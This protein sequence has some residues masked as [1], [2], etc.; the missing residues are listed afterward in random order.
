[1]VLFKTLDVAIGVT[2]L[3]LLLTFVASAIVELISTSRNW[4]ARMLHDAIRNM[5]RW[6]GL[7][8]IDDVYG[9]PLIVALSREVAAP[10][11]LDL[12]QTFGLRPPGTGLPSYIPAATFSG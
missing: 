7:V 4:R 2:F 8:T 5:L 10:S 6:S 9:S 3:Y 11:W 12:L 1:M